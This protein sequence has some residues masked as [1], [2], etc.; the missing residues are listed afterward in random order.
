MLYADAPGRF[1]GADGLASSKPG[2]WMAILVADCVPVFVL[3]EQ[4]SFVGLAHAGRRGTALGI[5][6]NLVELVK[7]KADASG[8]ALTVAL[9]PSIGGCCY[10]LDT[11]TASE[12]PRPF[13]KERNGKTFADLWEANAAQALSGGVPADNILLPPAC[14]CCEPQMFFSHRAHGGS[15][16][17]QMAIA[18]PGGLGLQ[19]ND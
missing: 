18:A 15:T 12:L 1:S 17:R 4:L 11:R 3:D 8:Q 9:G 14:T 16:G 19:R 13:V 5:T 10:E 7:S 6:R 2:L